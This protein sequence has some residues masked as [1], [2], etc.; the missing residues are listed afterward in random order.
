MANKYIPKSA[1]FNCG[2]MK[3]GVVR[4]ISLEVVCDAKRGWGNVLHPHFDAV[5]CTGC[6][7]TQ[8]FMRETEDHLLEA[9]AH[10]VVEIP[11]P[12]GYR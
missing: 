10:E 12:N 11:V 8:M 3:F 5:V 1:C 2:A 6:N 4:D 9:C 7:M